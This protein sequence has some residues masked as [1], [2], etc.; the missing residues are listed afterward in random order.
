[1]YK[2]IC[3]H[4]YIYIVLYIDIILEVINMIFH[5]YFFKITNKSLNAYI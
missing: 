1:M 5:N 2:Y 4:M 3:M